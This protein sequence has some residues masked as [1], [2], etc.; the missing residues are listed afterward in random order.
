ME[1]IGSTW[2]YAVVC[3]AL[4]GAL[5]ARR[6]SLLGAGEDASSP[7]GLDPYEL[8]LLNG[9][10]QLAVTLAAAAL[11]R[12]AS[13]V[14]SGRQVIARRRPEAAAGRGSELEHELFEAVERNP[15]TSP[16]KLRRMVQDG[17]AVQRIAADLTQAGLLLDP[18]RRRQISLLWLWTVPLLA[19]G[20]ARVVSAVQDAQPL[21]G[22]GAAVVA[23]G[24]AALWLARDRPRATASGQRLLDGERGGRRN[25]G[26]VPAPAEVP[27]AIAV[28]GVGAL[29]VAEPG[30]ASA[31]SVGRDQGWTPSTFH[32]S[33]CGTGGSGGCGSGGG[34]GGG[35][36]CG[37]GGCGGGG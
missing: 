11:H 7:A 29:W 26:R 13:L 23:L 34:H 2:T 5:W 15:G 32:G 21:L 31:W 8:A 17:P 10:P 18:A 14:R 1:W 25:L 9:G 24:F 16:R 37:G 12:S 6:R 35:G 33:G 28:Y 22:I 4:V 27:M 30:V 36:G 19:L 3:A 20:V